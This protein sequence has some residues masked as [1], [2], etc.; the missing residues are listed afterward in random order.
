LEDSPNQRSR[1]GKSSDSEITVEFRVEFTRSIWRKEAMERMDETGRSKSNQSDKTQARRHRYPTARRIATAQAE[2]ILGKY[3][4]LYRGAGDRSLVRKL[5]VAEA[6]DALRSGGEEGWSVERVRI[7]LR[8]KVSRE[9]EELDELDELDERRAPG[10]YFGEWRD[11]GEWRERGARSSVVRR[12]FGWRLES[13][14]EGED[15]QE[16]G[17]WWELGRSGGRMVLPPIWEMLD[18]AKVGRM[19]G[20]EWFGGCGPEWR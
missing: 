17:L 15:R 7:W 4:S 9:R 16:Q 11:G 19:P 5:I 12:E 10:G 18:G 14:R 8:N 3:V 6:V 20:V 2:E 1:D 13:V